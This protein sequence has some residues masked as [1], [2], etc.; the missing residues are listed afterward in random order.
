MDRSEII[1][2]LINNLNSFR[3]Y[4]FYFNKKIDSPKNETVITKKKWL[5]NNLTP[6]ANTK[7]LLLLDQ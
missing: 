1:N 7:Y 4:Y 3:S 5:K 2:N 6:E